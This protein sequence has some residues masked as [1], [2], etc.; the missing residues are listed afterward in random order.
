MSFYQ[1]ML[2]NHP[3]VNILFLVVVLMGTLSFISMPREQDPE[4]SFNWVQV[5]T[6]Q[7]G[8]SAEDIEELVTGPLEDAIRGVQNLRFVNSQSSEGLSNILVR[9]DDLD[10][11]T[12]DKRITDLR[13]EIQ[14]KFNEELPEDANDPEV[15]ELNTSSGFPTALVVVAGQAD[16]EV[17][18]SNAKRIQ[19]DL[20]RMK[21]VDQVTAFGL[22][23]PELL[24]SFD[25]EALAARGIRATNI[26]NTLRDGFRNT[27][28]GTVDVGDNAWLIRVDE[29][30]SSPETLAQLE[31]G[32]PTDMNSVRLGEV[33]RVSRARKDPNQLVRYEQRPAVAMAV[34]KVAYTNTLDLINEISEY[35]NETDEL[36]EQAGIDVLVADDQTVQTRQALGVME[37]NSLLGL[38]LVLLVCW[39]F[40]GLRIAAMVTLGIVF[41]ITG[42]IWAL[43]ITGNTLNVSVLL[44]I[45]IVL[46]MLVDDAV[47]VVEAM[48]YR[49]Q[50]GQDP[51]KS[52][53]DSIGEV[54]TPVTA[55]VLTT[56]SAF[57]PLMLLP[58]IIG[59]FMFVIPFVVTVG[60][61]VSLVE[62]FWILPAHVISLGGAVKRGRVQ[63][64]RERITR[65]VR[66][67]YG[68]MLAW[69]IRR[70]VRSCIA[71][72][73]VMLVAFG[74]AAT[75]QIRNEF[76]TFDPVRLFYIHFEMPPDSRLE[77]TLAAAE[78][79]EAT[80]NTILR[81]EETRAVTVQAGLK[82]TETEA[83][84]G[85]QWA[86]IQVSLNP[87]GTGQRSVSEIVAA[88]REAV[89]DIP[90]AAEI[91]FL[92]ISG[93]PPREPPVK[94][95]VRGD[96]FEDI[97]EAAN[98]V[99][100]IVA[101]IPGIRDIRDSE[102]VGRRQ[103]VIDL[104]ESQIRAFGLAPS[105]VSRLLRLH[106]DG[107]IVSTLR[108][109]GEKV[110]LRVRAD[111][112]ALDR[113][114]AVLD[115]PIALPDGRITS[116]RPLVGTQIERGRGVIQHYNFRRVIQVT[117][118]LVPETTDTVTANQIV[119]DGW[120][121]I[122]QEYPE[123]ELDFTGALDD[124]QESL[125]SML[126]LM[127]FGLGLIYLLLATQ[128]R[129]YFQPLLILLTV[130]M[131][132]TG[133]IF[134]LWATGN[135]LSLY[136]IYGAVAL[137]GIAVNAAIVLID[138]AN[139]RVAAGMRPLHATIY[140]ARRRVIPVLMTTTTTIAGLF[141]LAVGLGGKS[142]LWG[143]VAT[144]IVSGLIVASALT[145]FV[146]PMLYRLAM[147]NQRRATNQDPTPTD[148]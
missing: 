51:L 64:R 28:A 71:G 105:E 141:S 47:V 112:A 129:S 12:A 59:K 128:F 32:S 84:I 44:G 16:D 8:A 80:L 120:A 92:E 62:A 127:L 146:I 132:L 43:D 38:M 82:F 7:P 121:E 60:L 114:E 133:V 90:T 2:T 73:A 25:P 21:G 65:R 124:I 125:D 55:A 27:S 31:L 68:R 144:S 113:I 76:F 99:K 77:D 58:G 5:T 15:I 94:V 145:L 70:P 9:L 109:S 108:S 83:L 19:L 140:A 122:A 119:V 79:T 6:T 87:R 106:T 30:T 91:T 54:G 69:V 39:A 89:V 78:L 34:T 111:D 98:R 26:A 139:Q 13:R 81:P 36:L 134:G 29:L 41:S 130:P 148:A 142:L 23:E 42:T 110:E 72:V 118:D 74:A 135:P 49:I 14:A 22:H 131:S 20:E 97:G 57:L 33:A 46:G 52:A 63:V 66:L 53:L 48:Y 56:I 11:R 88:V 117:A 40:L 115:A 101:T 103:L 35:V 143:P 3:L 126:P 45:V 95:K 138:A 75:G 86:Q 100:D 1:R 4:I 24:V 61:L 85:D 104:Q 107:E 18:R 96:N 116:F 102:L 137:T 50:R 147:R 93:G 136:T 37:K 123:I 67:R 10:E 17:L